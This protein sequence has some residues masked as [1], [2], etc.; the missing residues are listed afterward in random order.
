LGVENTYFDAQDRPT[1]HKGGYT[2][3]TRKYDEIGK[4]LR[5]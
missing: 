5:L 2:K 4:L 3:W 1:R